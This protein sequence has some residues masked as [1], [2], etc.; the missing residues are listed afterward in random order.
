MDGKKLTSN[1]VSLNNLY[2]KK[3]NP[4][5]NKRRRVKKRRVKKVKRKR[6]KRLKAS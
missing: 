1:L 3:K 2:K 4:K 5:T 6:A